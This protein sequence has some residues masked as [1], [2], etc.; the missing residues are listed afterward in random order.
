M[1]E[2]KKNTVMDIGEI[3][4]TLPHRYPFVLIDK[5]VE[6]VDNE[7]VI[8][9]KNVTLNEPFFQGH[10]PGKPVMPGVLVLEAMAQ[11]AAILAIKSSDG[12]AEGNLVYLVGAD[13]VKWRKQVVPGDTLKIVMTSER[14]RRPYWIMNGE[15]FV[16]EKLVASGKI[17]AVEGK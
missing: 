8:A 5:V 9:I 6:F 17:S 10:F 14:K 12:V 2:D 1:A 11:S 16:D 7:K 13:E 4:A 15:V 3:L